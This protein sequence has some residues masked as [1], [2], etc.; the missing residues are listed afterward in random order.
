M[1]DVL[2]SQSPLRDPFQQARTQHETKQPAGTLLSS[3]PFDANPAA[4]LDV[5]QALPDFK[6]MLQKLGINPN[7][8]QMTETGKIQLVGRLR[9]KLGD[10]LGQNQEALQILELFNKHLGQNVQEAKNMM[11]Q[12]LNGANRTLEALFGGSGA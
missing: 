10:G 7:G 4:S 8:I 11:N 1:K 12:S 3:S 6:P 5:P 9:E 2:L